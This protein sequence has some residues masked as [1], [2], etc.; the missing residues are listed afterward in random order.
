MCV[1]RG[2]H[3][4][5]G[6]G[7]QVQ[8]PN[9]RVFILGPLLDHLQKR[10]PG[11]DYGDGYLVVS[12]HRPSLAQRRGVT[13]PP[14]PAQEAASDVAEGVSK[15]PRRHGQGF[16]NQAGLRAC[17]HRPCTVPK[18]GTP[19]DSPADPRTIVTLGCRT[20]VFCHVFCIPRGRS[21]AG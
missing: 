2:R 7:Q 3:P 9:I 11:F 15:T 21:S 16:G 19:E 1:R 13:M 8:G 12:C 5:V 17:A 4:C 18:P 6:L 14:C 20:G 10:K